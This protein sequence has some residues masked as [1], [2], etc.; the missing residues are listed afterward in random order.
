MENLEQK[1]GIR[2]GALASA[3]AVI[4]ALLVA[5]TLVLMKWGH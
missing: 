4:G 2:A 3:W 5:F 1:A